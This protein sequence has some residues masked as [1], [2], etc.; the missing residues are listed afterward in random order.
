PCRAVTELFAD[1]FDYPL[2]LGSVHNIVA[3]AVARATQV[4]Q[5]EDLSAVKIGVHD[6]IHQAGRP[7]L[8]GVDA[9]S[10]YCYLLTLEEHRD[11][12]TWGVRLL[13]L[14][15]RGFAP[16]CTIADFAQ[17]LRCGQEQALPGV[18]CRGDVFHCLQEVGPVVRYLE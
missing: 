9:P 4:N 15:Q 17:G 6:E 5:R 11:A 7:V 12:D 14:A 18:P 1:F 3:G 10:T 16:D 13:E 8:V 2:S